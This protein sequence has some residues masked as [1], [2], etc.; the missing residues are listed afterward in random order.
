MASMAATSGAFSAGNVVRHRLCSRRR[1]RR[2]SPLSGF[3]HFSP[4]AN[5]MAR[6]GSKLASQAS[7]SSME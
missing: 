7:G 4:K 5:K 3:H 2:Y 6:S 1:A